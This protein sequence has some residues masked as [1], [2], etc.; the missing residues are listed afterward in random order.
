MVATAPCIISSTIGVDRTI[1]TDRPTNI[2]R[3]SRFTRTWYPRDWSQ[4]SSDDRLEACVAWDHWTARPK[5]PMTDG[6]GSLR[7]STSFSSQDHLALLAVLDEL[8]HS[9]SAD[10]VALLKQLGVDFV[11]GPASLT[12]PGYSREIG[13][14]LAVV[15][16]GKLVACPG[17]LAAAWIVHA[18]TVADRLTSSEPRR[19]AT[20]TR[21]LAA[22]RA[23]A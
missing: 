11:C 10:F 7:S 12:V 22:E 19:K 21:Y 14:G 8:L 6:I 5:Y 17:F 4:R 23:T 2:P 3:S 18:A 16:R 20:Q 13:S 1:S 15:G 9:D